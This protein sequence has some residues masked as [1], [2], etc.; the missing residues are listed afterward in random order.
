MAPMSIERPGE[1]LPVEYSGPPA[2]V[3]QDG[4]AAPEQSEPGPRQGPVERRD[5]RL[6]ALAIGSVLALLV[7]AA[8]I[9][10][11]VRTLAE[12]DPD[13]GELAPTGA[14]GVIVPNLAA[15][16]TFLTPQEQAVQLTQLLAQGR[17]DI[18][19]VEPTPMLCAA[20]VLDTPLELSGR[21]ERDGREVASTDR[22]AV[23]PPGFGDCVDDGGPA[24]DEGVYQFV[25]V[26]AEGAESAAGTIVLGAGIVNQPFINAGS[27]P[28]CVIRVAPSRAGYFDAF[29]LSADPLLPGAALTLPVADVDHEIRTTRCGSEDDDDAVDF[30]PDAAAPLALR[31]P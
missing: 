22:S 30:T 9:V 19:T 15:V 20:V 5:R 2:P 25:V 3:E 16:P 23:G 24:L 8:L 21:W 12:D 10:A 29:D 27:A 4:A 26:D 11:M 18:A 17:H 7:A 1:H 14:L 31:Q 6:I 13:A 28:I